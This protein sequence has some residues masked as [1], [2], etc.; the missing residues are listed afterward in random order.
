MLINTKCAT[1]LGKRIRAEKFE[2]S[3][4]DDGR[5]SSCDCIF[6]KCSVLW[7]LWYLQHPRWYNSIVLELKYQYIEDGR[8]NE[9]NM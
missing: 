4:R 8:I 5:F 2:I 6:S 3:K 1:P 7:I 9:R